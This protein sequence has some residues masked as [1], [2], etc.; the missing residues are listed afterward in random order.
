MQSYGWYGTLLRIILL[1]ILLALP[2]AGD[3]M[4]HELEDDIT[5]TEGDY[6]ALP[7]KTEFKE[8]EA[9]PYKCRTGYFPA[10]GSPRRDYATCRNDKWER[11]PNSAIRCNPVNCGHPVPGGSFAH[12]HLNEHVFVFPRTVSFTCN[13]GYHLVTHD[14]QPWESYYIVLC[15]ADGKWSRPAPKCVAVVCAPP[16]PIA[17]GKFEL[18]QGI[19]RENSTVRYTCNPGFVVHGPSVRR[20]TNEAKWSD[21]DPTCEKS[22][23]PPN[24]L[25]HGRVIGNNTNIGD[26][27]IYDC[28]DGKRTTAKCVEPGRW[29]PEPPTCSEK[30]TPAT[31]KPKPSST[32]STTTHPP[33]SQCSPLSSPSNGKLFSVD[34]FGVNASVIFSC[35]EG[36]TLRGSA[37]LVCSPTGAWDPPTMPI[38]TAPP[39]WIII[40]S[41]CLAV[42]ASLV[43]CCLGFF[44]IMRRRRRRTPPPRSYRRQIR[45]PG[46]YDAMSNDEV[47]RLGKPFPVTSL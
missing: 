1:L 15:G 34:G 22:C 19:L 9:A 28:D 13:P 26:T 40:L 7:G 41:V 33:P 20:C 3:C 25:L 24:K 6:N 27:I 32:T 2:S 23:G 17:N 44:Y 21:N 29:E 8:G 5:H 12:G 4:W 47:A 11:P 45:K 16:S 46:P 36:Y 18:P 35:D 14:D 31:P 37:T 10:S 30:T 43:I 39:P 38:C 42:L